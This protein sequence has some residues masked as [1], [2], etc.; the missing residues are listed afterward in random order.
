MAIAVGSKV[1][2][3]TLDGPDMVVGTIDG[4]NARVYYYDSTLK[5]S[6]SEEAYFRSF[7]IPL[8]CLNELP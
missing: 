5:N 4:V 7:I 6:S 2:L 8:A 3:L 1:K